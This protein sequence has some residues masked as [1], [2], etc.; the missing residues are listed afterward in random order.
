VNRRIQEHYK[1][2]A[3]ANRAQSDYSVEPLG[4]RTY[5]VEKVDGSAY[6]VDLNAETCTCPDFQRRIARREELAGVWCKHM[7]LCAAS[8]MR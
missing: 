5:R 8:F 6:V 1:R 2:R 4:D 7:H 3:T